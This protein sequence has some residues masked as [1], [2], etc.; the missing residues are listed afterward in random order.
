M[1]I[2]IDLILLAVFILAV[3]NGKRRGFIRSVMSLATFVIS[4]VVGVIFT[5]AVSG[6]FSGHIQS[7]FS[8]R[9]YAWLSELTAKSDSAAFFSQLPSELTSLT[10]KFGLS[11]QQISEKY[12]S[13]AEAGDASLH[14]MSDYISA[15]IASAVSTA[16]AFLCLFIL[17]VI[18]CSLLF[19]ALN[20]VAK[21]PG[22]K[23]LNAVGGA[24]IGVLFGIL[25]VWVLCFALNVFGPTLAVSYP[26]TFTMEAIHQSYLYTFFSQYL[27]LGIL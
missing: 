14:T 24:A 20:L 23:A 19:H 17:A 1:G 15:P 4:A 12:H 21:L 22:L 10:E 9:I 25:W 26:D 7:F 11:G 2:V 16:L 3:F 27:S 5:P 13:L 8:D 6:L 18:V